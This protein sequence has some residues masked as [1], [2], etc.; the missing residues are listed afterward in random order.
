MVAT[1]LARC[2]VPIGTR[3]PGELKVPAM[4]RG[5]QAHPVSPRA[6]GCR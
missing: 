5:N 1:V 2:A 4:R 6:H 3:G